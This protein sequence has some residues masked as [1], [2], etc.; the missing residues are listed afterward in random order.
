[1]SDNEFERLVIHDALVRKFE[2]RWRLLRRR[3][4]WLGFRKWW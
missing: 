1:M 2:A 3:R 4:R